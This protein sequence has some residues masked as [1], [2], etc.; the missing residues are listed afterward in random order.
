MSHGVL[1]LKRNFSDSSEL[2]NHPVPLS[3]GRGRGDDGL[4]RVSDQHQEPVSK[5]TAEDEAGMTRA[6][7]DAH[8]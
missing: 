2:C 7:T 4:R 6:H 8:Q 3:G 1:R 5:E